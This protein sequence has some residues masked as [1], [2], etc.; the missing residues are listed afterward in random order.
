MR[1]NYSQQQNFN[2]N[3][4]QSSVESY[5]TTQNKHLGL[6]N[7]QSNDSEKIA[8][9]FLLEIEL[10]KKREIANKLSAEKEQYHVN[11]KNFFKSHKE[12]IS[13]F[14]KIAN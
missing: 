3:I 10:S 2:K 8:A 12:Y 9:A 14:K 5:T 4:S 11:F 13:N 1:R 6:S 7:K